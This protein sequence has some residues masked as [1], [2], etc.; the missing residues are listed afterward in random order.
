M[1]HLRNVKAWF[2]CRKNKGIKVYLDQSDKTKKNEKTDKHLSMTLVE[3]QDQFED[4]FESEL[5]STTLCTKLLEI[6]FN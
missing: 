2:G 4:T 6:Y 3:V 5:T 1:G